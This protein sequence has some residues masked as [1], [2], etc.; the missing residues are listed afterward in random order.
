MTAAMTD[1]R[2]HRTI[3]LENLIY[4]N[5]HNKDERRQTGRDDPE[6]QGNYDDDDGGGGRSQASVNNGQRSSWRVADHD[7]DA[8]DAMKPGQVED[9]LRDRALLKYLDQFKKGNF[10]F[11]VYNINYC[12]L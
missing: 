4:H 6:D 3:C 9:C 5:R 10:G 2:S 12:T 7:W 11:Y 8:E 1:V